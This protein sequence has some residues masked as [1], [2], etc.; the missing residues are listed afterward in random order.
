MDQLL[1]SGNYQSFSP[2][3]KIILNQNMCLTKL[4]IKLLVMKQMN[5]STKKTVVTIKIWELV[6]IIFVKQ[7]K[8]IWQNQRI[9]VKKIK[10]EYKKSKALFQARCIYNAPS[11]KMLDVLLNCMKKLWMKIQRNILCAQEIIFS[12]DKRN[13]IIFLAKESSMKQVSMTKLI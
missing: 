8:W 2:P 3:K 1:F 5:F 9:N 10:P 13:V 7:W 12:V 11:L 4:F 6:N